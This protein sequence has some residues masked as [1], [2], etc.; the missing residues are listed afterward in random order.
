MS[1]EFA[2]KKGIPE[3]LELD[4]TALWQERPAPN[5]ASAARTSNGIAPA[6]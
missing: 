3:K 6:T 2:M 4:T 5:N 1:G